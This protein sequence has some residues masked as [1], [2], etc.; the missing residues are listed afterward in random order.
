M[1]EFL[2]SVMKFF[3][4][5]F[6]ISVICIETV[7]LEV[8]AICAVEKSAM[9]ICKNTR[10]RSTRK[11]NTEKKLWLYNIHTKEEIKI[12]FW[13]NGKY[14][15]SS[16]KQLN[17]FLRDHRT[18]EHKKIDIRIFEL[19]FDI[20]TAINYEKRIEVISG[21]R[22]LKTNH[23]LNKRSLGVAKN[24]YHILGKAIDISFPRSYLREAHRAACR[25]GRGGVG[26]YGKS[27]FIHVDVRGSLVCW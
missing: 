6:F 7:F 21:Y 11:R 26:F 24:S 18:G 12:T 27:G 15:N 25:L 19:V 9:A 8:G 20:K 4:I 13:K 22:S 5:T 16:I 3:K 14:I 2:K 1:I 17:R 10:K 23:T